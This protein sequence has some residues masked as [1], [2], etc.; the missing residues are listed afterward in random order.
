MCLP[1]KVPPML[2]RPRRKPLTP[3]RRAH[4]RSARHR[5]G[6]GIPLHPMAKMAKAFPA[7]SKP[8]SCPV[9]ASAR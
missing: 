2:L 3:L 1:R 7:C 9:G 6:R 4:R 8:S 5:M